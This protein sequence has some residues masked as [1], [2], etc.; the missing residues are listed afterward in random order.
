[1]RSLDFRG[2]TVFRAADLA[3]RVATTPSDFVRRTFRVAGS[4]HC[5]DSDALRLDVGRLRIFYRRHG[6]FATQVDTTVTP[7]ADGGVRVAFVIREGEAV[8]VDTLRITGLD[9]ATSRIASTGDLGLQRGV[10]FDVTRLQGAIDSIKTRLRNNGF[11]RADVAASYTV[12]DSLSRLAR[13]AL[14]VIPGPMAYVG[15]IRVLDEPVPGSPRRLDD[16]TIRRLLGVHPGD[17]YRE[18]EL[19][20]AQRTLYQSD[21]FQHVEVAL[22]ADSA[23]RQGDSL[24]TIDVQLRENFLHQVDTEIGWAVLDCFKMRTQVVDKNWLG[25]AR[26]LELT[27]QLSKIGYGTPT[28]VAH[29]GLCAPAI[30]R[31]TFSAKLNYY[32][33]AT[34]RFPSLFGIRTSPSLSVYSERHGEYQAFLRTTLVGGEASVTRDVKPGIPLRLAYTLEFGRTEAQPALLCAVFNRC[35]SESRKLITEKNRPLAVASAHLERQRTDAPLNPRSG[36]ILRLDLRGAAREIGSDRDLQFVKGLSDASIYRGLTRALTFAA[37]VRLGAVVGRTLSFE[38]PV[39]FIPP[40]ERLYAGGAGS[41]RGFQQNELGDLI[42]IAEDAP[43]SQEGRGDTLFFEVPSSSRVR[44]V[45]PVGG[46]SL[47]V[48]N[49]EVRVRSFF[50]PE[51]IQYTLFADAGDVWQR[52]RSIG[53]RDHKASALFLNGLR[54]TPGV[55]VRVFT[56]VGPFQANVGYNP[57]SRPAGAIYYDQAPNAQGFAPLYCVSPG[58]RLPAVRGAS[59][60]YEQPSGSNC[61]ATFAPS[62]SN[63]FLSRLTFTFSIGPDF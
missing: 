19:I 32:A 6:Y 14:E 58:N 13:V 50:Y 5:L 45:V 22:A 38:D 35:D 46:N 62:Q 16:A 44:R 53:A 1:V 43:A 29:G 56:P 55:G 40:E 8:R 4:K 48:M 28:R 20:E 61:P 57:F 17:L 37:R 7:V 24:V 18:R 9:A 30:A 25:G 52:G 31:D 59:G 12:F 36:T 34:L 26:R 49:F 3:L 54:W 15:T 63:S 23:Q 51:L 42:Y 41:V 11:P 60:E 2:N 39:G 27:G 21:L 33:G 47:I 10:V